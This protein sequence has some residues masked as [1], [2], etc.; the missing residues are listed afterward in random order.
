M[1]KVNFTTAVIIPFHVRGN[2]ASIQHA[3]GSVAVQT[4]LPDKIYLVINGTGSLSFRLQSP[5]GDTTLDQRIS[6]ILVSIYVEQ[7]SIAL[8]LNKGLE[9]SAEDWIFRLD[10]DDS[11]HPSRVATTIS[12]IE[13]CQ[14]L[15][16]PANVFYS[17]VLLISKGRI[18]RSHS[19][20]P[21]FMLPFLLSLK[22][23]IIH[24]SVTYNRTFINSLGG[25]SNLRYVEDYD[26]WLRVLSQKESSRSF[27]RIP[28]HLTVYSVEQH[29]LKESMNSRSKRALLFFQISNLSS[30]PM[31]IFF[32]LSLPFTLIAFLLKARLTY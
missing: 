8:A 9:T 23:P 28:S 3:I 10:A 25:Y 7:P 30:L 5:T 20:P 21:S 17:D 11:M 29:K 6:P 15:N 32:I 13:E 31:P 12:Y 4:I 22:N 27:F 19:S 16:I 18:R 26:L 24:P 1:P 14:R 2:I